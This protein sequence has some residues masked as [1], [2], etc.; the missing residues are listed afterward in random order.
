MVKRSGLC[1]IDKNLQSIYC[2]RRKK[3]YPCKELE[4]AIKRNNDARLSPSQPE[5]AASSSL[6]VEEYQIPRGRCSRNDESL[7]TRAIIEF[8]EETRQYFKQ[9]ELTNQVFQLKWYDDENLWEYT[10]H[11][12]FASFESKN[13]VRVNE[14]HYMNLKLKFTKKFE[15]LDPIILPLVEYQQK[16]QER[17]Y[18]YGDNNYLDFFDFINKHAAAST[19]SS[20]KA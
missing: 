18:L 17:L 3:R 5:H 12:A 19:C 7:L 8:I 4:S 11:L 10:I 1:V 15:P 14:P 2:V 16:V 20:V 13:I 9:I 6:F